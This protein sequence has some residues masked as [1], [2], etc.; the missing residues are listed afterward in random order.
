[1][2]QYESHKSNIKCSQCATMSKT[3]FLKGLLTH[4]AR[5]PDSFSSL[6]KTSKCISVLMPLN[7]CVSYARVSTDTKIWVHFLK[8]FW[9]WRLRFSRYTKQYER[10]KRAVMRRECDAV[11]MTTLDMNTDHVKD[12]GASGSWE[13]QGLTLVWG[14]ILMNWPL[15][16]QCN[17]QFCCEL[18]IYFMN[19]TLRSSFQ[20]WRWGKGFSLHD[21]YKVDP[22]NSP[23]RHKEK[24]I[25]PIVSA[26]PIF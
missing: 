1:M 4:Q 5:I 23:H 19:L 12:T 11:S 13:W 25:R 17:S 8:T 21:C 15:H 26:L 18:W 2:S 14:W 24:T 9:V 10:F 6:G 16:P 22:R 3:S 7:V 20:K